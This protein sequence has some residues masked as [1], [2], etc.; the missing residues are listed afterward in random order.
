MEKP[1]Q[2]AERH[3]V[4]IPWQASPRLRELRL[5]GA[6]LGDAGGAVLADMLRGCPAAHSGGLTLDLSDCA[7]EADTL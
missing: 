4:V 2:A 3:C 7:V 5:R 1:L 6:A